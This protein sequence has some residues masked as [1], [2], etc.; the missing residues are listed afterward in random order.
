MQVIFVFGARC[1]AHAGP[2]KD[3]IDSARFLGSLLK[4]VEWSADLG[5]MGSLETFVQGK[6][7]NGGLRATT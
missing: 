6:R 5:P 3:R 7:E 1:S 4:V 2:S